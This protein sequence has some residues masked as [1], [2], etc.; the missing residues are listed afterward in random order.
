[1]GQFRNL[2]SST[3]NVGSSQVTAILEHHGGEEIGTDY[4]VD[5]LA[6]LVKPFFVRLTEPRF[7]DT[8]VRREISAAST[9]G[10]NSQEWMRFVQEIRGASRPFD[11]SEGT[12]DLFG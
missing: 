3:P 5:L 4:T 2:G 11:E 9:A 6:D 12:A 10:L 7:L 1:M 8:A